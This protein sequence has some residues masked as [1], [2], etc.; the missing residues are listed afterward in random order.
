MYDVMQETISEKD[1]QEP[2]EVTELLFLGGRISANNR[3]KLN[4]LNIKWILNLAGED[5][6][7][8]FSDFAYLSLDIK[9]SLSVTITPHF[10]QSIEFIDERMKK[11]ERGLVHCMEGMSRSTT[12]LCAYLI[13]T[14]KWS[15]KKCLT[16]IKSRRSI[17]RPNLT[18]FQELRE[19]ELQ[20]L[21]KESWENFE[22][23]KHDSWEP[24]ENLAGHETTTNDFRKQAREEKEE[25]EAAANA[26]RRQERLVAREGVNDADDDGFVEPTGGKRRSAVWQ[27]FKAKKGTLEAILP[28]ITASQR[29]ELHRRITLWLVRRKRPLT[30]PENDSEFRD[31]FDFIFAGGYVPPS[32]KLVIQ[33]MLE[34]PGEGKENVVI[35]MYDIENPVNASTAVPNPDG[36]VYRDHRLDLLEW[37]IVKGSA[38]FLTYAT[39][40]SN[41]LQDTK[42]PTA[43]LI[44]PMLGKVAHYT[45]ATPLKFENVLVKI[46]NDSVIHARKLLLTDF[47]F[48][49]FN[50]LQDCKLEDWCIATVLDPRYKHFTF[51]CVGRWMR[52][53]M[54]AELALDWTRKCWEADWKPKGDDSS[55]PELAPN[56]K[57]SKGK[58]DVDLR[59]WWKVQSGKLPHLAKMARQFLAPPTSTSGVEWA[60]S[61]VGICMETCGSALRNAQLSTRVWRE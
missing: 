2:T 32:Y 48:R 61:A 58:D 28:Q 57:K 35:Q 10:Q 42:Y 4:E 17:V 5:F 54:T 34:L 22:D 43:S 14:Q 51:H 27:F 19:Y 30:I 39:N 44:L 40:A 41:I 11:G 12:I 59:F 20:T 29:K 6:D 16:H 15:L 13:N 8:M 18:F 49:F 3:E 24:V 9:D 31:I 23:P 52:G 45:E 55:T 38:Y 7:N 21:G 56:Q 50:G 36:S 60:L 47:I 1:I 33:Q 26:R 53:K 37:D 46:T 25:R